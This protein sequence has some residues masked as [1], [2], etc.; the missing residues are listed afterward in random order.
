M[1]DQNKSN[2]KS[3]HEHVDPMEMKSF[4]DQITRLLVVDNKH[5]LK[6]EYPEVLE[7]L[8]GE[9]TYIID[10]KN[11]KLLYQS[12]FE[13][14]LGYSED[15]VDFDFVFQG[16]HHE[17]SVMIK[18]IIKK[19]LASATASYSSDP[20]IQLSMTYR[21][22]RKDGSFIHI[23]SQSSVYELDLNG[24]LS[25]A[26]TRLSDISYLNLSTSVN[27][28]IR[29][30]I[31][32]ENELKNSISDLFENPFTQREMEVIRE[33]Q[34]GGSN[35][36]IAERLCLSHHTIATHRKNIFRK[37]DCKSVLEL[38]TY[39]KKLDIL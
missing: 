34:K 22:R 33:I 15:E 36:E 37:C 32:D 31:L 6:S 9:C 8:P 26:L 35:H 23:L 13:S 12:G 7:S 14:L 38:L 30:N 28:S 21:R 19:V 4:F 39:C 24:N 18:K 3:K 17:D 5:D 16:Y 29:S 11:R 20:E 1:N 2:Q 25:K 27:W 10:F